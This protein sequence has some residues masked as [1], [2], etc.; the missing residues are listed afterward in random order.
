MSAP[1][2]ID[3][4]AVGKLACASTGADT[5]PWDETNEDVRERWRCIG[6]ALYAEGRASRNADLDAAHR[7]AGVH[8]LASWRMRERALAAESALAKLREA[9]GAGVPMREHTAGVLHA[10]EKQ[11]EN[12]ANAR[13]ERGKRAHR[14]GPSQV[15]WSDLGA[16]EQEAWRVVGDDAWANPGL[17]AGVDIMRLTALANA[18]LA[19][20]GR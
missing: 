16:E 19:R 5:L 6:V 18:E 20:R 9:I 11:R 12:D 7:A 13:Q 15:V 17:R 2:D 1:A 4:D 8:M 14:L 3:R 10:L